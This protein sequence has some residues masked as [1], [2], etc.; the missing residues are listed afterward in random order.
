VKKTHT[1]GKGKPVGVRKPPDVKGKSVCF[2][3][4]LKCRIKDDIASR[5]LAE[6]IASEKGMVIRER[7]EKKLKLKFLSKD[8]IFS[9]LLAEMI[10]TEKGMVVK[11]DV[12][13]TLDFLVA[14][15]P[16][17]MST[18]AKKARRYGVRIIAE[19]VF[20]HMMGIQVE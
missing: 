6:M 12:T 1:R 16:D 3:G 10:A 7:L 5:F 14:G 4:E 20:W 19:P 9:Q 17:S 15:D 11:S 18:K 8:E 13:K 2:T